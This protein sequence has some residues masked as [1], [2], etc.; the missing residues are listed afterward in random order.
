MGYTDPA[1]LILVGGI[2]FGALYV[3]LA[4][5]DPEDVDL[6]DDEGILG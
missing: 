6:E 2:I 1:G 5:D 3:W 4:P